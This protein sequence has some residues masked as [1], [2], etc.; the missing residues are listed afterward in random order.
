MYI[1]NRKCRFDGLKRWILKKV[2]FTA[3]QHE[4]APRSTSSLVAAVRR[5]PSGIY[6]G[7]SHVYHTTGSP[8]HPLLYPTLFPFK[9]T[10]SAFTAGVGEL[11]LSIVEW[12]KKKQKENF[13]LIQ[14]WYQ[15]N[16]FFLF[17]IFNILF[18]HI[19][20]LDPVRNLCR[21]WR[22]LK[23]MKWRVQRKQVV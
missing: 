20:C 4:R 12:W 22:Q 8:Y 16:F 18:Q 3:V 9:P 15:M 21:R 17:I 11:V 7:I 14:K 1:I 10:V 5:A 23:R 2:S 13:L 6:P 19:F